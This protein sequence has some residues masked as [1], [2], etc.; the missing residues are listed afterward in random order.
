MSNR[1]GYRPNSGRK[2]AQHPKKKVQIYVDED[3]EKRINSIKV[4]QAKSFSSKICTLISK[5]IESMVEEDKNVIR[6]A[7][8]FAGMGGIRLGF[9]RALK[10]H[11]LNGK[12][13]FVSEIKK[14]AITV[15][16][17]NFGHEEITGDI[18]KVNEEDVPD[19]DYILAGFPCQAFSTA[20]K[21]L[22][23]E[24]TRG[25]LFFDVARIIKAKKPK[26]FLLEN[27]EGLTTHDHGKTFKVI[28][29][30]LHELGYSIAYKV[31]NSA[32]FGLAQNRKRI[33]IIGNRFGD[34]MSLDQLSDNNY[35]KVS[36]SEIIEKDIPPV[37][38]DFATKLLSHYSLSE[39]E[40]KQ[41]K[42]KR[43]GV[44]NIHS[45]DFELKGPVSREQKELLE[46]LLRQRRNKKWADVIGIDWMDGMPLTAKMIST[47]Y[48]HPDLK[49]MLDDLVQ[50]GYLSYEYPKAKV[51][52]RRIPD[53]TK[54][55]GY[56]IVA[57]KLSF[58][59]T[60]ILSP[61]APTPTLVATDM[62][63]LGVPV[64]GGIRP[65]TTREGLRLFGYPETYSLD[66]VTKPKAYDLLG[67][68]VAVNAIEAVAN[69][70][71]DATE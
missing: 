69:V 27:V 22:G 48:S 25:T 7:D 5:G 68:T 1:G 63:H 31:L 17:D 56:N 60:K 8:L 11:G 2:K 50:K 18:T 23:F 52:N 29:N 70:L 28:T 42:D 54:E 61:D 49:N 34:E 4:I 41:I 21:Q 10:K 16:K 9:E 66:S 58:E 55:K 33:Y 40:G 14:S 51:G 71:L 13:V 44:N 64:A 43:G 24:D 32:D 19:L 6:F 3:L 47:F 30:T 37:K 20:G 62:S 39:V 59:Y 57:G 35:P 36:L 65:L 12:T 46:M 67:N 38:D 26:G 45:W 15:Y 53:E